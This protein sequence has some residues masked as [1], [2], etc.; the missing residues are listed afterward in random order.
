MKQVLIILLTFAA[1]M[2]TMKDVSD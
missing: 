1:N 2:K